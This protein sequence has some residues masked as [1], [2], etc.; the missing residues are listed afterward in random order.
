[1]GEDRVLEGLLALDVVQVRIELD[2]GRIANKAVLLP[3][4]PLHLWRY[5]RLAALLRGLGSQIT[6]ADRDAI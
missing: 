5:Q 3:T 2:D 4:H 1:M 6:D